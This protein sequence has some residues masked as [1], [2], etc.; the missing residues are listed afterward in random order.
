V[1]VKHIFAAMLLII[2]AAAARAQDGSCPP[3]MVLVAPGVF[4]VGCSPGDP[5]CR[6][7]ETPS[8]RVAVHTG[9]CMDMYEVTQYAFDSVMGANPSFFKHC[10][11]NCPVEQV[12][13]DEARTFC[14]LTGK[15]LP[16]EMQW[17]FAARAGQTTRFFWGDD[18]D[19]HFAWYFSNSLAGYVGA[20]RKRGTHP[21]GRL[22]PNALGLYD[23][24]GNVGEW[25]DHCQLQSRPINP[26]S[27]ATTDCSLRVVRGGSWSSPAQELRVSAREGYD[28]GLRYDTVGFRCVADPLSQP[29]Q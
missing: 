15:R 14:T 21:V 13:W 12:T 28:S 25:V 27:N 1:I 26:M 22:D 9:F 11:W 2:C 3:G 5:D 6:G 20:V 18:P 19:P 7:D 23:M 4:Q 8:D 17:E 24:A 10:G 29:D 16:T